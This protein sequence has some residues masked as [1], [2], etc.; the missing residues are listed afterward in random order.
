MTA[1]DPA[2]CPYILVG[3]GQHQTTECAL[4]NRHTGQHVSPDGIRRW[5]TEDFFAQASA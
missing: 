3:I 2:R 4:S 5:D 1:I